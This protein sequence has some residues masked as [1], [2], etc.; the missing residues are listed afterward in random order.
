MEPNLSPVTIKIRLILQFSG[1][2]NARLL[3]VQNTDKCN[4]RM[5][6]AE[7]AGKRRRI[8]FFVVYDPVFLKN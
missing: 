5:R 3:N 1:A 4:V 2:P 7:V 8:F 6:R